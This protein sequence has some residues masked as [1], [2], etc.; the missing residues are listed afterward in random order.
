MFILICL[1]LR[2]SRQRGISVVFRGKGGRIF[3]D[4]GRSF[5]GVEGAIYESI[6][7]IFGEVRR[8]LTDKMIANAIQPPKGCL[9]CGSKK[10]VQARH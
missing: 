6:L 3:F 7:L 10:G 9:L 4:M 1:M 2:G 5:W 8:Y